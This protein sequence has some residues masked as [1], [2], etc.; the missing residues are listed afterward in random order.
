VEALRLTRRDAIASLVGAPALAALASALAA[1]SRQD[2]RA[3]EFPG[4]IVG[5][6]VSL[7]HLLRGGDLLARPPVRTERVGTAI[8]GAGISGLSAAWRLARAGDG[9]F[10]V[11]ELEAAPGGTAVAGS[12]DV[13]RFPW[14]AH[15]VPVPAF[16]NPA[17]EAIL[18][19]VGALTSRDAEGNPVW[20]EE[21][22]CREP[23][24]RL[25][26]GNRWHAGLYPYEGASREDVAQVERFRRAMDDFA[27]R[28]DAKGRRAF[29]IP[30]RRSSDDAD[31]LALDRITM[32]EWLDANG[33]T[34]RR[35]R[36]LAEYG[37]RDDFG[38]NLGG[39]S[40]WAG[41]HY[42][43]ARLPGEDEDEEPSD[44]LTWP[45]GNG[46]LVARLAKAAAG[47]LLSHA[48]VFDVVPAPTRGASV[49]LRYL[50]AR[51]REVVA[52][53][54]RDAV[55]G[56][57]KYAASRVF[58]PWRTAP[59]AWLS[60]LS[61]APWLV[62]NLSL[63]GRPKETGAPL[64]WDNVLYDS[65]SLG[66]VVATH[67]T[68]KDHGPTVFT[69]YLPLTD[70]EP[71]KARAALLAADWKDLAA[72]VLADLSRAHPDLPGLVERLDVVRWG[73][74]MLRPTPGFFSS[75]V[76]RLAPEGGVHFAHAD[77]AGLPLFEEAQDAG[78][79]AA[80]AILASRGLRFPPL[81]A[82]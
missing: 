77:S 31:L 36:W 82:G 50:D 66:Y 11:F 28:K 60:S 68:G 6:D 41:I 76:R 67:Q 16:P 55:L 70:E 33:F 73:H 57:P 2:V 37:C 81:A 75:E 4:G 65:R 38:T 15:Y 21:M 1:C 53:E 48:L 74:A 25:Y 18:E 8:V 45:E 43:A 54:A 44:F 5:P 23:E 63:Q 78:V 27:G 51:T 20:A 58:A 59:P 22:L 42:N 46:R 14:G 3:F 72:A 12:N 80:E 47:R 71:A 7:G 61:Y 40:A 19:E 29:A 30:T 69:Y 64:A 49:R 35:L 52:V 13:S 26:Y 62:A 10:R 24:E 17:L 56:L 9:D 79:R 39:V 32:A 34:S